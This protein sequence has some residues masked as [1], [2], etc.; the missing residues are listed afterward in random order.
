MSKLLVETSSKLLESADEGVW[1]AV[2]VTPGQGSSANYSESAL[3]ESGPRAFKAGAHSYITHNRTENGEPNPEKLWAVLTED[4]VYEDGVGLVGKLK[5][6]PHWREFV[7][8]VAPHT[9]LSIYA[10]GDTDSDGNLVEFSESID[11]GI[12]MVS[13][14]GRAGSG[15]VQKMYEAAIASAPK[16]GNGAAIVDADVQQKEMRTM[17]ELKALIESLATKVDDLTGKVDSIVTLSESAQEA[18]SAKVDAFEVADEVSKAVT[19]AKLPEQGR[20][21]VIEAVKAGTA[22]ADAVKSE[23]DYIKSIRESETTTAPAGFVKES[24]ASSDDF[25]VSAWRI[26]A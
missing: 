8:A 5:V 23:S 20:V 3:R 17:D 21:R 7:E 18:A 13:Y 12:D 14:P 6:M 16:A 1:K 4:A 10:M 9:A 15:L 25:S 22:V 2:L 19:E 11:N 26:S 24:A